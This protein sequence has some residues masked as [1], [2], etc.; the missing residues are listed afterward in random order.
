MVKAALA[1][2]SSNIDFYNGKLLTANYFNKRVL[3]RVYGLSEAIR[4]G[5][6]PLY[7]VSN[8]QF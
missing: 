4:A 7:A 2:K 1:N 3:P 5:S 8:D 6:E